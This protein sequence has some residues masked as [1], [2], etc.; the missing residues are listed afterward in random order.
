MTTVADTD[1]R[2]DGPAPRAAIVY[3]VWDRHRRRCEV[4]RGAKGSRDG[5]CR[6]GRLLLGAVEASQQP[7]DGVN[8]PR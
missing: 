8:Q 7:V 1:R 2:R 6:T 5:L 4:C 3:A